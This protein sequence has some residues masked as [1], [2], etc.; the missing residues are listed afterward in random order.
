[1]NKDAMMILPVYTSDTSG[2]CSAL[3]E[4][5][6]MSVIHDPSGCNSTYNTHDEPRWYTM[7][8]RIYLSGLMEYDAIL[9]NES[10]LIDDC[11]TTAKEQHPRFIALAPSP[12]PMMMGQDIK[13]LAGI[14]EHK[15]GIPTFGIAT[16]GM[17]SYIQGAS[18][19]LLEWAKRFVVDTA[20]K[21]P[22][23][24]NILGA[25]PLDFAR[26]D[27]VSDIQRSLE[28]RG[29]KVLSVWAMGSRPEEMAQAGSAACNLVISSVGLKVAK[30]FKERFGTPYIIAL[31]F[32]KKGA[33]A[34]VSLLKRAMS[35]E[36]DRQLRAIW[37]ERLTEKRKPG[38]A[39][40]IVLGEP[41]QSLALAALLPYPAKVGTLLEDEGNVLSKQDYL[42][43]GEEELQREL[44]HMELVIGDP[45]F[46]Y[47]TNAHTRF[48]RVPHFA[49]SGRMYTD[50]VPSLSDGKGNA[51][52]LANQLDT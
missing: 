4:L 9:G 19:A 30:Y 11:V 49:F 37:K 7:P 3:Y 36:D 24:I 31:P 17:Q 12:I 45:T 27:I 21:L 20:D 23:T 14:I 26:Q 32:G 48:V 16:D 40:A 38:T 39:T 50:E 13:A 34:L 47:I 44:E 41:V 5:D 25:T 15:T 51:W 1:M 29:M 10:K 35:G 6:G 18:V 22:G 28:A 33:D 42:G 52:L 8:S 46:K 43:E 2:V